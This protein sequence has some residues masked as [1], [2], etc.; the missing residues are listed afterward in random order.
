VELRGAFLEEYMDPRRTE[1]CER[2]G[3]SPDDGGVC[4]TGPDGGE[5]CGCRRDTVR[6]G[7][8]LRCI[9]WG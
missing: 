6:C 8:V 7:W 2:Y 4:E 1:V 3:G 5:L 9:E